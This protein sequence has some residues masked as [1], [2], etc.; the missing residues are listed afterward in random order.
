VDR[1]LGQKKKPA[2][3]L[4]VPK[5]EWSRDVI[6]KNS[7]QIYSPEINARPLAYQSGVRAQK[8]RMTEHGH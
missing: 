2:I 5:W 8:N 4:E 7:I 6:G 1:E 3:V